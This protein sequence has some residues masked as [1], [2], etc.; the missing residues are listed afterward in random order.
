[1]KNI[2]LLFEIQTVEKNT[3]FQDNNMAADAFFISFFFLHSIPIFNFTLKFLIPE[4]NFE[5]ICRLQ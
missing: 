2:R 3:Q 4:C 5:S 1:M